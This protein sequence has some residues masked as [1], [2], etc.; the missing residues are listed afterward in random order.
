ML[1]TL[2]SFGE[3][4]AKKSV[5]LLEAKLKFCMKN[6]AFSRF[7][8]LTPMVSAGAFTYIYKELSGGQ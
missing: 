5:T 4:I 6:I 2:T 7:G 1:A 8:R 3:L